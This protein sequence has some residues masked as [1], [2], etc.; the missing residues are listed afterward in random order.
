VYP[1]PPDS[2]PAILIAGFMVFL[3]LS[4]LAFLQDYRLEGIYNR[5]GDNHKLS[6]SAVFFLLLPLPIVA[7]SGLITND[8]VSGANAPFAIQ[9]VHE[10]IQTGRT[11]EGD[12][13]QL[14]RDEGINYNAIRG[15]RD[16]MSENYILTLTGFDTDNLTVIVTADFDNGAWIECRVYNEQVSFCADASPP[17]TAGFS[18]LITGDPLPENCA[19]CIIRVSDNWRSWLSEQSSE[20]DAA[21]QIE[22]VVQRGTFTLMRA[23]SLVGDYAVECWFQREGVIELRSCTE[24]TAE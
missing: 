21:P 16:I 6:F 10:I 19:G 15:V 18:T 3:I 24:T 4:T 22:K 1:L 5:L 20:F 8:I 14:S 11:Y 12:L 23:E 2:I 13:F 9:L 17:Y 7:L